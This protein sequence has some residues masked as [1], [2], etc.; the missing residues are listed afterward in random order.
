MGTS[1]LPVV[2]GSRVLKALW[3]KT[4]AVTIHTFAVPENLTHPKLTFPSAC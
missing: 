4:A 2:E 3:G 1:C